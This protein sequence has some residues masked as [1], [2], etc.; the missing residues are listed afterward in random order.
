M[1]HSPPPFFR[2]GPTPF[3]RLLLCTL[4]SVAL[5]I[6]DARYRYLEGLRQAVAVTIYPVQRLAAAP[7]AIF[8]RIGDFFVTQ[9]ALRA[10]NAQRES[11]KSSG[12][13]RPALNAG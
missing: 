1:E 7:L 5:L 11:D 6:A 3:V 8:G 4:L 12:N 9:S 13:K 10:E 2:R